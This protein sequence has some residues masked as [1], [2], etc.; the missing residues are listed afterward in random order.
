MY[1]DGVSRS[2]AG[3]AGKCAGTHGVGA[4]GDPVGGQ[5][6]EIKKAGENE[7]GIAIFQDFSVFQPNFL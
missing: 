2:A 4:A 5:F 1:D 7:G 3:R 6:Q